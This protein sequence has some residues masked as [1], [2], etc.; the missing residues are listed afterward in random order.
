M[1]VGIIST[2]TATAAEGRTTWSENRRCIILCFFVSLASLQYGL[3][4]SVINSAQALKGFLMVFGHPNPNAPN[5]YGISPSFQQ[6][7]TSMMNVG[8][9][10]GSFCLET[11]AYYL[12]RRRDFLC[13]ATV[14]AAANTILIVSTN[15]AAII[16]GRFLFGV[17]NGLFLGCT[18][19]YISEVSPSHLRGSLISFQQ[20]SICIGTV[21]GTV[22]NNRTKNIESRLAYQ[23]PLFTLYVIPTFCLVMAFVI[24]ESPRWLMLRGRPE[25]ARTHLA[26]LRGSKFPTELME[27]ELTAI[28]DAIKAEKEM[29]LR[30]WAALQLMFSRA[31][32]RRT[33]LTFAAGTF[34]G[35]SGFPFISSYK[36]YFFQVAG[37]TDAFIDS[38]LVTT[39]SLLGAIGGVF[40]NRFIGRRPML[41]GGFSI[42]SALMLVIGATWAAVPGTVTTGKVVVAMVIIFQCVFSAGCGP[43]P[44][45]VGGEIPSNRLRAM[46]YGMGNGIGFIANFLISLTT[47]YFINPE[48]LNIGPRVGF[49]WAA[50]NFIS[51]IFV[52]FF[53]PETHRRTLENLDEMFYAKIPARKF[54]SYNCTGI[55]SQNTVYREKV[56]G[57]ELENPENRNAGRSRGD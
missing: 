44:F 2:T 23:I 46:T 11:C 41:I 9:I 43:T 31:E 17:S 28:G 30:R 42:Q 37:S 38:I 47:P 24:P 8:V 18:T 53:L 54:K 1:A 19:I 32:L 35:A 12:G 57:M 16:F 3:D 20:L 40:L 55:V 49:I 26:R 27:E 50:S 36:T 39:I 13:A 45:I 15:K 4:L 7:I 33:L 52:F 5:G 21:I 51:A 25:L 6:A 48:A 34:H 29:G 22:V 14:G 10:V 56:T